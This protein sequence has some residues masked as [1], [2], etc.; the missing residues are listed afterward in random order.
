[1]A[2]VVGKTLKRP[3]LTHLLWLLVFVK[4]LTPSIVTI[5]LVPIPWQTDNAAVVIHDNSQLDME[6]QREVAALQVGG[7]E[8]SQTLVFPDLDAGKS[9]CLCLVAASG[10]S[11]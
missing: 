10:L 9:V 7:V 5:P 3:A 8:S 11:I 2:A 6:G 1:M 4:L